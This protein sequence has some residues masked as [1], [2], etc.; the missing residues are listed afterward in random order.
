MG[1]YHR[2]D[3]ISTSGS[4]VEVGV[5]P[6]L[7]LL[8]V[9]YWR[10][11]AECSLAR[12][13]SRSDS[14]NRPTHRLFV[15]LHNTGLVMCSEPWDWSTR[16]RRCCFHGVLFVC[17]AFAFSCT[18]IWWEENG[19]LCWKILSPVQC[20][21]GKGEWA[22]SFCYGVAILQQLQQA[23]EKIFLIECCIFYTIL[24]IWIN[25]AN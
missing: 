5:N 10:I 24:L 6:A 19:R 15:R 17:S 23:T 3:N 2:D 11:M 22:G 20:G 16:V 14:C 1:E 4:A 12:L 25:C 7:I 21:W 13:V 18:L 8:W 9:S